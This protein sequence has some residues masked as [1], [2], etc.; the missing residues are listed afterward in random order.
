MPAA[1]ASFPTQTCFMSTQATRVT[2]INDACGKWP[3][4]AG[5]VQILGTADTNCSWCH[6][7]ACH[8]N[9]SRC[10]DTSFSSVGPPATVPGGPDV[11]WL[12]SRASHI[13]GLRACPYSTMIW[14][15]PSMGHLMFML[16]R[17]SVTSLIWTV[18]SAKDR[19][20]QICGV[21][22]TFKSWYCSALLLAKIRSVV[23]RIVI[24]P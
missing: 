3:P 5:S 10:V 20:V 22:P 24:V 13:W 16:T 14:I 23:F 12:I 4:Y 7:K 15:V 18:R 17:S 11:N 8:A 1:Y 2:S 21:P 6:S 9:A 19:I